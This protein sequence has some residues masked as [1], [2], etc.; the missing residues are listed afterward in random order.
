MTPL[1]NFI[2][3]AMATRTNSGVIFAGGDTGGFHNS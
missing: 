3:G 1:N 2:H